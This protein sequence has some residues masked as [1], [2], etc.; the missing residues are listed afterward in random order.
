M[1]VATRIPDAAHR[2][3][4]TRAALDYLKSDTRCTGRLGVMGICIGGHLAFRAAMNPDVLAATC[5]Y[6]TDIHKRGLGSRIA[7]LVLAVSEDERISSY[8]QRKDALRHQVA[9][10]GEEALTLFAADKISKARELG[11]KPIR[12]SVSGSTVPA[13]RITHYRRCLALLR[14]RLPDSPLVSQLDAELA[15]LSS[16]R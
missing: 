8:I 12:R 4:K 9:D 11:L 2:L 13:R 14:E 3:P 1:G 5:F 10:A 16:R 7:A 6:A 15:D